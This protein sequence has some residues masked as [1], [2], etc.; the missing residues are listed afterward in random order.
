MMV[1]QDY[2]QNDHGNNRGSYY[3]APQQKGPKHAN[4]PPLPGAL[5]D[6]LIELVEAKAIALSP[7]RLE[8]LNCNKN[9]YCSYHRWHGHNLEDCWMFKDIVYDLV[10]ADVLDW[11]ALM[12]K[13]RDRHKS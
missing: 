2:H 6:M 7:P 3:N 11:N 10:E 1:P 9:K 13:V 8:M 12:E 5:A 4:Y